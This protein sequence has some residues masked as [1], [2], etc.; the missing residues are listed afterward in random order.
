MSDYRSQFGEDKWIVENLPHIPIG[1][2][3]EVGAYDG[4]ESSNTLYFEQQGAWGV[5]IEADNEM[6]GKCFKNRR[7][8][9]YCCAIGKQTGTEL[10]YVNASARGNSGLDRPGIPENV[11]VYTLY[12][13]LKLAGLWRDLDLLSIDTE[14]TE[15]DVIAG[16]GPIR[17]KIIIAEFWT[18]PNPPVPNTIKDGIE[19]LGYKEVHRTEANLIFVKK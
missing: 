6:A 9:T 8:P 14:G 17:P 10:F 11:A 1:T 4:V 19:P 12:E 5:V 2:F 3:C 16:I 15:L 7:V 18:Q 13:V